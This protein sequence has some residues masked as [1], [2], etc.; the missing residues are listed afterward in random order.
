MT[1]IA[2]RDASIGC[3]P[4]TLVNAKYPDWLFEMACLICS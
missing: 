2:Y 3:K 4:M 1:R